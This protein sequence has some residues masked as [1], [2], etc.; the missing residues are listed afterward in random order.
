MAYHQ[1][2]AYYSQ[3]PVLDA[4]YDRFP[5][6][7]VVVLALVLGARGQPVLDAI[8]DRFPGR[9]VVVLALVLGARGTWCDLNNAVAET[10]SL[11]RAEKVSLIN[12]CINGS[13]LIHKE[14]M[15]TTCIRA[16]GEAG[17]GDR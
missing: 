14:F 3:Q 16:T 10:L 8:Y 2:V 7:S 9:S 1:K 11:S 17:R 15:R 13:V 6:R 5:G 4:I 12:N